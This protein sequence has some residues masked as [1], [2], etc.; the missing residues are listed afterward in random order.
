MAPIPTALRRLFKRQFSQ[1][2]GKGPTENDQTLGPVQNGVGGGAH[3]V[4]RESH[5]NP[6]IPP[7]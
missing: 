2:T 1:P 7:S 6:K 3:R 4:L 5:S